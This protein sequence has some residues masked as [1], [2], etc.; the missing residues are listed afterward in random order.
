[1]RVTATEPIPHMQAQR[2]RTAKENGLKPIILLPLTTLWLTGAQLDG[3]SA[4]HCWVCH[5]TTVASDW[6]WH[7]HVAFAFL[8]PLKAMPLRLGLLS[9]HVDILGFCIAW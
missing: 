8:A 5:A 9:L 7:I 2:P 4:D 6:G 1:M 3:S